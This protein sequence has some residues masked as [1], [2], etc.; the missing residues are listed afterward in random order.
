MLLKGQK[1]TE[2]EY[3]ITV[4]SRKDKTI[5]V[6]VCDQLP[7]SD[8]KTIV[9]EPLELSGA[10]R[11]EEKGFLRWTFDLAPG[12]TKNVKLAWTV[13]WPKDKRTEEV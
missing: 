12:E 8:E 11:E 6:T 7:I 1:K 2:Y 10:E 4:S 9:I 3:E 13:A 5:S